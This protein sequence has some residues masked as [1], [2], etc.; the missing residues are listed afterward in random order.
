MRG[1]GQ[2][3]ENA[4]KERLDTLRVYEGKND[5]EEGRRV[6]GESRFF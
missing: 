3:E 4:S 2:E 1:G 6:E 5:T